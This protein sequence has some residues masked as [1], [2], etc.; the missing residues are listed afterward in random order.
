MNISFEGQVVAV[1]GAAIGFG[2][3]IATTF[4]ALGARVFACDIRDDALASLEAPNIDTRVVDLSDRNAAAA[5]P[6]AR[7]AR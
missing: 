1:S 6:R 2:R 5:W 3:S 4:A 7:A